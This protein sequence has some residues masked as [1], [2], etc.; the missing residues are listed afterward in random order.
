MPTELDPFKRIQGLTS[1]QSTKNGP[2]VEQMLDA[3]TNLL[4]GQTTCQGLTIVPSTTVKH[5]D[6]M[7]AS[8]TASKLF[9]GPF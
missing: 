7:L 6:K 4:E 2:Q 5:V 8:K 3:K 1:I 9:R